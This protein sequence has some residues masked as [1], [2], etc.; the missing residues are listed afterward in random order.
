MAKL[1]IATAH[2][3]NYKRDKGKRI[4]IELQGGSPYF[5][6]IWIDDVLYTITKT[7]R[8]VNIKRLK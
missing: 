7:T 1:T 6:Y 8:G 2:S 4:E 5:Q 3:E